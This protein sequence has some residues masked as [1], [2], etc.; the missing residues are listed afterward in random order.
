MVACILF[1]NWHF[2]GGAHGVTLPKLDLTA[3]WI[4]LP[5]CD[6]FDVVGP[7]ITGTRQTDAYG[8]QLRFHTLRIKLY[9][10]RDELIGQWS[11]N[12]AFTNGKAVLQLFN[13]KRH[14]HPT[15][16]HGLPICRYDPVPGVIRQALED[17]RGWLSRSRVS[18]VV[19]G[20]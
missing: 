13:S 14:E 3:Q 10:L 6:A 20:G 4:K 7:E 1:D 11:D 8:N 5:Y 18:Y 15:W 12:L 9:T 2:V 19:G 17:A 16:S